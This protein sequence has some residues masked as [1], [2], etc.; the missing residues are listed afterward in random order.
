MRQKVRTY[1]IGAFCCLLLWGLVFLGMRGS[2]QRYPLAVSFAY[3]CDKPFYNKLGVNPLFNIIK[4]AESDSKKL[5]DE[6]AAIDEEE[7]L[8]YVLNELQTAPTDSLPPLLRPGTVSS[9]VSGKPHVVMIFMESMTADNLELKGNGL[10]L[11]PFLR[12]LRDSSIYWSNCYSAGVHTNNGIVGAHYGFVPNFAKPSMDVN[13]DHYTGLPYYLAQNGYSTMCFVTGNPQYDNMNSFWR[14]NSIQTIY[15]QYDYPRE[16]VVNNF[17]VPD[18]Y[19]FQWGLDKLTERSQEGRPMF[20]TFLTVSNHAPYI[21]PEAYRARGEN[22]EQRIIAYSDDALRHFIE[23]VRQTQWGRN[24]VF[25]LVADH[26]TPRPSPYDMTLSYNR[27]P[28]FIYSELL[29]PE[30]IDRVSAQIDLW[31]SVLSL[32][33]FDYTNDCTGIDVFSQTRRYAY[34]VSN[35]HLGVC[36]GEY[37]WCYGIQ[38]KQEHLYRLGSGEN[39]LS[40]EPEKAAD[41]RKYGLYMLRVNLLRPASSLSSKTTDR[42][43]S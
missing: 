43:G 22:D 9:R 3:F 40:K 16:K 41:M 38:S 23:S 25:V 33:G 34:F 7:A 35:E 14:D 24:T 20:A 26:G 28:I 17:G 37:F 10:W 39:L 8:A 13:A 30:R 32:L 19:M 5:P 12:S 6:I 18:D 21:V 27:I 36:D 2:L 29:Q 11:T 15:S 4:S 1:G 42:K 31:P